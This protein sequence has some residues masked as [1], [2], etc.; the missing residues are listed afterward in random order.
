MKK[1]KDIVM[2]D[3]VYDSW[4][5]NIESI[6]KEVDDN[7]KILISITGKTNGGLVPEEVRTSKEYIEA[8]RNFSQ[9]FKKLQNYNKNSPVD[10]K[11]QRSKESRNR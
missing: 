8:N 10:F 3:T 2:G 4:K 1:F 11:R 5:K 9:S 6:E 7:E